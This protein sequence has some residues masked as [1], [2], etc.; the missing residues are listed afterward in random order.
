MTK[1]VVSGGDATGE[2]GPSYLRWFRAIS[3]AFSLVFLVYAVWSWATAHFWPTKS[4]YV[5]FWAAGRLALAGHPELAYN[6]PAHHAAEQAVGPVTGLLPFAYPP[7]FLAVVTPFAL[8][9]FGLAFFAWLGAT[10]AVYVWAVRRI[11]PLHYAFAI[12]AGYINLLIGQTGFLM[13]GIFIAGTLLIETSP[14]LAGA[15]LGLMLFKPQLALLLPVAM[16]AGRQWRVIGGAIMS[17]CVLLLIGLSLGGWGSY[18]AFLAMLPLHVGFVRAGRLPWS[19]LAS[20]FA[21]GRAFGLSE[22]SALLVHSIVALVAAA[23]TARAWWRHSDNRVAILAAASLLISPYVWTYDA[24]LL[25]VPL[26]W[27]IARGRHHYAVAAAWLCALVPI[28]NYYS[29][30]EGPNLT[31]VAALI[32]LWALRAEPPTQPLRMAGVELRENAMQPAS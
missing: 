8:L 17:V 15:I 9:P 11:V 2:A 21:L 22:G 23:V 25:V 24:V 20:V 1:E 26:G 12:P 28:V 31:S 30:V 10:V 32:C 27:M 16:L 19:E 14:W 7:P 18:H 6:I 13:A 29:P 5:T 3:I 4:D